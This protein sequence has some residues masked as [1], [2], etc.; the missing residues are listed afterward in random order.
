MQSGQ[1]CRKYPYEASSYNYQ[2]IQQRNQHAQVCPNK[3]KV[4]VPSQREGAAD[5]TL[6]LYKGSDGLT[7]ANP[8]RDRRVGAS[9]EEARLGSQPAPR[10]LRHPLLSGSALRCHERLRQPALPSASACVLAG[11]LFSSSPKARMLFFKSIKLHLILPP[12][13][14]ERMWYGPRC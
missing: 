4:S 14:N 1:I 11:V 2:F 10:P 7:A 6:M 13:P 8:E 5:T 12:S 3:T 9:R